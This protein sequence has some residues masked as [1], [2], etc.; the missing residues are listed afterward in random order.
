MEA[1]C[2]YIIVVRYE[3]ATVLKKSISGACTIPM[4]DVSKGYYDDT[5][6]YVMKV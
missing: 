5:A 1:C 2:G 4:A 3:I 6:F